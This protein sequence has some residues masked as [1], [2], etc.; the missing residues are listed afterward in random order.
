VSVPEQA[1]SFVSLMELQDHGDDRYSTRGARYPWAW[2]YGGEVMAQALRAAA[3]TVAGERAF[4][5]MHAYFVRS[6]DHAGLDLAVERVRDGRAFSVRSVIASQAG[7][8]VATAAASFHVGE[9][10]EDHALL[11]APVV[12]A[13]ETLESTGWSRL[14]EHRYPPASDPARMLAWVRMIEPLGDDPM[15][16]ACALGYCIDDLFDA[17]VAHMLGFANWKPEEFS[18]PDRL[19]STQSLDF[20][21]WLHRP[22]RADEWLLLDISCTALANACAMVSGDVFDRAGRH[23]ASVAQQVLVRQR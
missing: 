11:T 21:L 12:P 10:D 13:P 5:S 23:L 22:V 2:S 15:L 19:V 17:P 8:V 16:Q 6:G 1:I 18:H 14:F 3:A 7:R 20:G 9:S 4:Q